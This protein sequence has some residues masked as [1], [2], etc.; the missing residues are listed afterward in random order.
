MNTFAFHNL[1]YSLGVITILVIQFSSNVTRRNHLPVFLEA[2]CEKMI[3][4]QKKHC[5]CTLNNC[6]L[7]TSRELK[8]ILET[9]TVDL[10]NS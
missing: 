1:P 4:N 7:N 5:F 2:L 9:N 8:H 3:V 6:A 10:R